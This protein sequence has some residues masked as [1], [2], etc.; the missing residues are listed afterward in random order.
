MADVLHLKTQRN[1]PYGS[2]RLCCEK[3]GKLVQG[4]MYYA[5]DEATYNE[6]IENGLDGIEFVS[7]KV[8]QDRID[9]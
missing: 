1:Q 6:V 9:Y 7:C 8:E 5:P 4:D 2:A 3:C